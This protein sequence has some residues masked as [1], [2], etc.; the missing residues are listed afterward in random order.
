MCLFKDLRPWGAAL[1][2]RDRNRTRQAQEV[3]RSGEDGPIAFHAEHDA[4]PFL[5]PE[6]L[7]NRAWD[8]DLALRGQPR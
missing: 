5:E 4:I 2:G 7:S 1:L 3:R 6:G 8:R